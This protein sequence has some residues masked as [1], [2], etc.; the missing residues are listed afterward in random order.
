MDLMATED[1]SQVW[2]FR[3]IINVLNYTDNVKDNL[4]RTDDIV[5]IKKKKKSKLKE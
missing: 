3:A 1:P 5:P 2:L 4:H